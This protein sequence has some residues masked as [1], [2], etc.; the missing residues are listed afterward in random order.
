[1][2]PPQPPTTIPDRMTVLD[3]Y[4]RVL[5]DAL[6]ENTSAAIAE[7]FWALTKAHYL[8]QRQINTL[9]SRMDSLEM[10]P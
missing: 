5:A 2:T 1:M 9:R 8:L 7:E 6:S 3:H 4:R 10:K